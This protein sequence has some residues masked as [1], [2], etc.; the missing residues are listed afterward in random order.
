VN[1]LNRVRRA[2]RAVVLP[3]LV[4]GGAVALLGSPASAHGD[5]HHEVVIKQYMYL[6]MAL[7]IEQG[8][9]VTW[10][11]EDSVAHD[12]TVT[13]GPSSFHSPMLAQGK[14]WSHTF[15]APG[16][17]SYI[18]SVHPDMKATVKVSAATPVSRTTGS[19]A[20]PTAIAP[21][22]TRTTPTPRGAQGAVQGA[23]QRA[24]QG[25]AQGAGAAEQQPISATHGAAPASSL[26]SA[27]QSSATLQPLIL[28]VGAAVAVV[29]FCLL[30][31]ASRPVLV[32]EVGPLRLEP[33]HLEEA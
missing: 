21:V 20:A 12:V 3:V 10:T 17:Y 13:A 33:K 1:P 11:N 27:P 25:Q 7:T 19:A 4:A 30:L 16:T 23:A 22:V 32:E 9:T 14:S 8:E 6:P 31:M 15:T 5:G 28:V 26:V 18:C 29:L 24:A 2:L